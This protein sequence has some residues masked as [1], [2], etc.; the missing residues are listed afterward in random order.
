MLKGYVHSLESFGSVDG[1]GVRYVIFLSGCAMRCQFCHN[2]DTWNMK[3]GKEYTADQ[4]LKIALRYK[5]YWGEKGGITV[6]GGEP[7][8]QMEFLT[9]LFKKAKEAGIHTTLDTSGNPY[10]VKEPWHAQWLELMKYTDLVLLDIKQ[11][12]EQ[13]HRKLTGQTG[14]NILAMARELSDMEKPVWIRHV[15]VPGGSDKDEYLYRLA[16]FIHTLKNVQRVEVLPYH[17]LGT[18]KWE[19]LGIPYPLEGVKPPTQERIDNARKILGAISAGSQSP[20]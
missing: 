20:S 10:T 18:F 15:L 19:K 12:D 7:L 4:L 2:P 1:P 11:I 17:T 9:E 3:D 6:S 13:E 8:L 5:S 16:D 14:E